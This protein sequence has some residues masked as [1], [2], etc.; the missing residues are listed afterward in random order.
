MEII[1]VIPRSDL[2]IAILS[3][4]DAHF[5]SPLNN[6]LFLTALSAPVS[7][8]AGDLRNFLNQ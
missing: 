2:T 7:Q 8:R 4:I 6:L 3:T 5:Q 1:D